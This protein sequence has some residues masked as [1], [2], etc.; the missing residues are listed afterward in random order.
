M[1]RKIIILLTV[2]IDVLGIGII[3]P[4]LPFYVESFGT[5]PFTV[6]M[7]F[8]VF[9]FFSFFSAPFLGA[10]SDR[11][12]RRPVLI[13]SILSTAV[14][15]SIF[16]AASSVIWLFVGRII[17][18][19]AAGNFP[20]AQSY[21]LDIAKDDKERTTNLG[22]IGA[23][24]G[25]GF[26]VGPLIGGLLSAIS[27]DFPFWFVG[28]LATLNFIL[29]IFNLPETN[30]HKVADKK[31][32][33]NPFRPLWKSL[34]NSSLRPGFIAWF[35]FGLA[36][37]SQQSTFSLYLS[38]V[39]NFTSTMVGFVM[40]GMGLILVFNQGF[41]LKKIWL[42][43]F[44]EESLALWLTVVMTI[45]LAM[46]GISFLFIFVIGILLISIAQSVLRA[47]LTS[48]VVKKGD[49]SNQGTVLGV[50]NSVMSLS[51][52]IGPI[53]AGWLFGIR[54]NFPFLAGAFFSLVTFMILFIDNRRK[55]A[56]RSELDTDDI[57]LEEQKMEL[58]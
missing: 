17:D 50:L 12:G 9:S 42:K 47:V 49:R 5:S 13:I 10:L 35:L 28:G 29:A 43:Y 20:I 33:L 34:K 16:A 31:I 38:Q 27:L 32:E 15:W 48:Q 45:G 37:A 55:A 2:F 19:A 3:I 53:L 14:G 51:M 22:L 18:G 8:A 21:L 54:A 1:N 24:F 57:I 39:F 23:I 11:I 4:V 6:T 52:I 41:A 46:M 40:A 26:I 25:I 56:L 30:V 7:L 36:L 58:A 44:K